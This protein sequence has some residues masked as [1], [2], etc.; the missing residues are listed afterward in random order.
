MAPK[1]NRQKSFPV[2]KTS[3]EQK[4]YL[5]TAETQQASASASHSTPHSNSDT[6]TTSSQATEVAAMMFSS[7]V[8]TTDV[9]A[10]T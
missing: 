1:I 5:H 9:I 10:I 6:Q 7:F 8:E 3:P 4:F 2:F